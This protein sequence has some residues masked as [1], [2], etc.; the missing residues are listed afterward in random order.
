[1]EI[2]E[3]IRQYDLRV[4]MIETYSSFYR[5]KTNLGT[6]LLTK[7]SD[8]NILKETYRYRE[9]VVKAGFRKINRFIRT[10]DG[11]PYVIHNNV[12]YALTDDIKGK[13]ISINDEKELKMM[14]N[15]I[16]KFQQAL[17]NIKLDNQLKMWSSNYYNGLKY[18]RNVEE[19]LKLKKIRNE[20]DELLISDI[21]FHR[22][23]IAQSVELANKVEKIANKNNS[24]PK[25]NHGNFQL[26]SFILDEFDECWINDFLNPVIDV[27]AYDIAKFIRRLYK[28]EKVQIEKIYKILDYYQEDIPLKYEDKLWILTYL[29]YPHDLWKFIRIYYSSKSIESK[30]IIDQYR[31]ICEQ[32]MNIGQLY[33][34]LYNYFS[35]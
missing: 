30:C 19:N 20:M 1:M 18:I 15:S 28:G 16:S 14:V 31:D 25:L 33:Q 26:S 34:G 3:I 9:L 7:W 23:Q 10:K 4:G 32:Q 12:G 29:A 6:K 8:I 17:F 21:Q 2:V 35:I 22:K 27:A 13:I 5:L 24:L 11:L